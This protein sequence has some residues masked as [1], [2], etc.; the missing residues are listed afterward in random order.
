MAR[1]AV[2]SSVLVA[3][4]QTIHP[5][6]HLATGA[7][8]A[9]LDRG[10]EVLF[11]G[12]A[13]VESFSVL[14]RVPEP[15]RLTPTVAREVINSIVAEAEVITLDSS[16]YLT[17]LDTAVV[18]G[19]SGGRVYDA[20]IAETARAAGAEVLLTFNVRHFAGVPGEMAIVEPGTPFP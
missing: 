20:L 8:E 1:V 6:Y 3:A 5:N 15:L 16:T 7:L 12:H 17:F 4:C 13:I 18:E 10:D 11:P 9:C 2:D 19:I 14:T